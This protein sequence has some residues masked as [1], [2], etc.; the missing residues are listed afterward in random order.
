MKKKMYMCK[1]LCT[2][3]THENKVILRGK[4]SACL[5]IYNLMLCKCMYSWEGFKII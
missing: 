1:Q 3:V 2:M 4:S 5:Y